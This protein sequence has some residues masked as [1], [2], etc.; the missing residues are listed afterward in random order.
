[1]RKLLLNGYNKMR[2]YNLINKEEKIIGTNR[3]INALENINTDGSQ[4]IRLRSL[5][6]KG[7]IVIRRNHLEAFLIEYLQKFR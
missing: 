6:K 2:R 7:L 3:P 4:P 5:L 1:M